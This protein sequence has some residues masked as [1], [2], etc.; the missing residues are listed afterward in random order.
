MRDENIEVHRA[1][2]ERRIA[3]YSP[4][5]VIEILVRKYVQ[6]AFSMQDTR[7]PHRRYIPA[8]R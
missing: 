6:N 4:E 2:E 8:C 5:F 3:I 1:A 7:K